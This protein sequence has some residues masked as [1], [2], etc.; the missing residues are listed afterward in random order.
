MRVLV[1]DGDNRAALAVT[2]ALGRR[3]HTVVVAEKR[4]PSLAQTSHYCAGRVVYRDPVLNDVSFVKELAA[5]V[6]E[7]RIDVLLPIADITTS[8]VATHRG[9]FEPRCRVPI[10]DAAAIARAADKVDTVQTAGR[11]GVP[12]PRS[13]ILSDAEDAINPE[14][15]FPVVLKPH[16][17][18]VRTAAGWKSCSVSYAQT[19]DDLRASLRARPPHEFPIMLQERIVGPGVGVFVC[20][21]QG[22][23][24]GPVQPQATP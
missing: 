12:A 2:R 14:V 4:T 19:P 9:L 22:Q 23:A 21:D 16:R 15:P 6:A 3:G 1:T 11:L 18:R 24:G 7:Q 10:A 13:W 8:V 20:Y 17:S 5:T